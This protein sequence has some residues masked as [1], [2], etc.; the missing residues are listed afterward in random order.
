[1]RLAIA[2]MDTPEVGN[3]VRVRDR[4]WAVSDVA[5][6]TLPPTSSSSRPEHLLDLTSVEDDGY[7]DTLRVIWE[8]EPGRQVLRSATLPTPDPGR[9][10]PPE[11]LDA[12]IDAVRWGAIASADPRSLQ[13]PFR[14]GITIE[15]YQLDPVVRSLRTP[16]VNLLIAD[17][18]GLGKTIEA[19][20][21]VQELILR[22][23]ATTVLVVCPA[24]LVLKWRAEMAEKFG[25]EFRIVDQEL[26][27]R[28]RRERGINANPWTHFPRLI[29]SM[30]WLKRP[31]PMSL[32]EDVL[33]PGPA[34]YPRPFD[35]L[36]IDEVHNVAPAG[37]GNYATD[38]L[39]TTAIRR[40]A[41][42]FEHRLFL[43]ATPHNGYTE[44]FTALLEMLD[45]QRFARG[46]KPPDEVL[47]E[48]MVRRLKT[49]LPRKPDG[50]P[51]FPTRSIGSLTVRHDDSEREAHALLTRYTQ[52]RRQRSGSATGKQASEFVTLLLKKRMFSS[53][54]AFSETLREHEATLRRAGQRRDEE[55]SPKVL[56]AAFARAEEET[57]DDASLQEATSDAIRVAGDAGPTVT[58]EERGV[59]DRLRS[60]ADRARAHPDP[61]ARALFDYLERTCHSK[62]ADGGVAWN[63]ERVIVFTEYRD[64]QVWL[65]NLLSQ[66]G[67]GGERLQLLYGGMDQEHR[68]RIRAEFQADP[69]LSPVRILLAT[70]AASEGIDLQRSCH[71]VV[72]YEIPFSPT[73][74]EQRNGRVDRH[75][76]TAREVL[77]HHFVPEGWE[78]AE[79]GSLEGDLHFLRLVASK[80][81]TIRT[82]LG[83]AGPV[84]QA[85]LVEAML[86]Q[87]TRLDESP[88]E[89]PGRQA[90]NQLAAMRRDL[91]ASIAQLR[92]RVE[93]SRE[94]LG[95]SPSALA[96]AVSVGLDL[97]RQRQLIP[98]QVHRADGT[99][100]AAFSV[101]PLGEPW[102]RLVTGL[103]HPVTG[104]V[105]PITFDH[106]VA[107]EH[108]DVVLAHLGHPLVTY[109]SRLLRAEIWRTTDADM[110][111]ARATARVSSAQGLDTTAVIAFAR[112]VITSASGHRLHEEL[113]ATG[114]R[115]RAGRFARLLVGETRDFL[116]GMTDQPASESA[117][118]QVTDAWPAIE[119]SLLAAV[120]QRGRE[121]LESIG[122]RLQERMQEDIQ[123]A[124]GVLADLERR[125][126]GHLDDFT[127]RSQQLTMFDP[128]ER[129]QFDQ[130]LAA[131]RRRLDEIPAEQEREVAEV[132]RRYASPAERVFP[133][134]V[135]ILEPSTT[136]LARR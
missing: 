63:D 24:S 86:G 13:A 40:I 35:L 3:L 11:R 47:W 118:R 10:D 106:E 103:E 101:P 48:T 58:D 111:L 128:V 120:E 100:V 133:V 38:S 66:N 36:I 71:R 78:D 9:L 126:R 96:R 112:L 46:I 90:R 15:D 54:A 37:R 110:Q 77:V 34:V 119:R 19:G 7:G 70:D 79:P 108:D 62:A 124:R 18:V 31:R 53:P 50:S 97:G 82:D 1:M 8:V 74:L 67:L 89:K 4:L 127:T 26:L 6:S 98:T 123:R 51:R 121:V 129:Q 56:E 114:G 60:W 88:I 17:D 91:E 23:R 55:M 28:L 80:V 84:L 43:S 136:D 59:L 12:F 57:D 81:D 45:P 72:H 134:A 2:P 32:F 99:A 83:S 20:L 14:S 44:S 64:T 92:E 109:A 69:S 116:G 131:L 130:D 104:K 27:R 135:V 49:E 75:G 115:V 29:V 95:V 68:E 132:A 52:L 85:Q 22:H 30:D 21:V 33:P 117:I 39:R 41:P 93:Q 76:Q 107:A 122:R 65:F 94:D 16:R 102:S 113:I 42:Y 125:I 5:R 73:R 105:R 25:L 87:R 61:K